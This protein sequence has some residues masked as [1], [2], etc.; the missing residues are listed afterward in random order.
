M[1]RRRVASETFGANAGSNV[2]E[3]ASKGLDA[4]QAELLKTRVVLFDF[5]SSSIRPE[6]YG[7]LKAH[8]AYLVNNTGTKVRI[9]G[10][11]DE[12]GTREYNMAL[13]ERRAKVVVT[14]LRA[15]GV[16]SS[17]LEAVSYGEE[18]PVDYGHNE[19]A[20][21]KNRRAAISY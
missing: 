18:K 3:T 14:Y 5:D 20:W 10:H 9:E 6:F 8:A 17:Q 1:T 4:A 15:Q 19:M 12:R 21:S 16:K 2:T 7:M 13:G 11:A